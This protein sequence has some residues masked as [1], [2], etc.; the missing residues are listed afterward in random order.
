MSDHARLFSS[1]AVLSALACSGLTG[2]DVVAVDFQALGLVEPYP[3]EYQ[4]WHGPPVID[5]NSEGSQIVINGDFAL[6]CTN[7]G[8]LHQATRNADTL[9]FRLEFDRERI[10]ATMEIKF[11]YRATLRDV[12]PGQFIVRVFHE[13]YVPSQ[14]GV[15]VTE[16]HRAEVRVP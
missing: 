3:N 8:V 15:G 4:S 16:V 5:V 14:G 12:S 6:P 13:L 9:D 10:C 7:Y 11:Q 1:I 2:P